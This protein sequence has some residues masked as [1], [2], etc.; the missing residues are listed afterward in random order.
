MNCRLLYVVGQLGPGG[1]ERQ[2]YF[3]LQG[4]DRERYR[5]AVAVWHFSEA[6]VYVPQIRAL[7]VPLY[8]LPRPVLAS[9]K[10]RN[11]QRLV[12]ELNPEIVHSYSFYTSIAIGAVRSDFNNDKTSSGFVLG[13]LS[14][15]WPR[16]QIYNSF[17]AAQNAR[18]SRALFAP[19]QIFVVRNRLDLQKFRNIPLSTNGQVR[20]LGVGSL[21]QYKRWDRLL[22]A[23]LILKERGLHF[24]VEIAGDGPLRI[25]LERHA[26]DLE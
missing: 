15:R 3:L 8:S 14:A 10:L 9:S 6:D 11:F 13:R 22:R 21:L 23:A 16:K 26:S 2:L 4:M 5:P 1:L 20:I 25:S 19:K 17:T 7:G 18:N 24:L 12:K